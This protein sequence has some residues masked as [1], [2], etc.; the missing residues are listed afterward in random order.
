MRTI[1]F[2]IAC[3]LAALAVLALPGC[4][5]GGDAYTPVVVAPVED[6]KA[7]SVALVKLDG[8]PVA[9]TPEH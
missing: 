8:G 1:P 9:C 3:H 4:G 5:G 7:C 2:L 6:P